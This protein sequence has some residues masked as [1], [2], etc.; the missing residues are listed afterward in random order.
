[1]TPI[2]DF[3]TDALV[4]SGYLEK[5]CLHKYVV[6]QGGRAPLII[7]KAVKEDALSNA[8]HNKVIASAF[9]LQHK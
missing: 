7:K 6:V 8:M 4:I 3:Q 9:F 5:C 1:M 2:I